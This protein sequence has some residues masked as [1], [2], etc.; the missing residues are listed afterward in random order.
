MDQ[1]RAFLDVLEN[2]PPDRATGT[3]AAAVML[4]SVPEPAVELRLIR[5]TLPGRSATF[6]SRSMR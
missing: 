5:C 1:A 2:S 4:G 6:C 3:V